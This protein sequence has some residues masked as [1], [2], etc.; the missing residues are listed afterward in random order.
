LAI[1]AA[2]AALAACGGGT[3][4]GGAGSDGGGTSDGGG[5]GN[6][7]GEA[8]AR[9]EADLVI[10]ADQPKADSL[11]AAA[12]EWGEANGLTVAVQAV[13]GD[14]QGS[15]I[16][17]NQAGN[18]PD[19]VIGAHD[20]IGNLVQ[21]GAIIPVQL[22][23]DASEKV[24]QIGLTAVTYDGQTYGVPY[25]VETIALYANTALTDN[26]TPSS[27]GELVAAGEAGGAEN[28]LSVQVGQTGDAYHMQPLYTSGGGYLFGTDAAGNL[29]PTDVGVGKKGSIAAAKKIGEL[30]QQE[31]LKTSIA[32]ENYI[33]LFTDGKAA[34]LISGPWAVAQIETADIDYELSPVP[35]FEG[36][37]PPRPFAGV[38]SFFVASTGQNQAFAQQFVDELATSPDIPE[39][40]FAENKLPPVNLELQEKL[41]ADNPE[42]VDI[43][44]YAEEAEPMPSIPEMSAIWGPLGQAEAAIVGGADPETTMV[45]AGEEIISKIG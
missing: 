6:A 29:D 2:S 35:G 42:L 16:T 32:G 24:A 19:I 1:G 5:A 38:N 33:D 10:W 43:A 4:N 14:L 13:A 25:A 7:V 26:P 37:D 12:Q 28:V 44:R 11:D 20:W 45:S 30:G 22:P 40:M 17:A 9:A 18:G 21:N 41:S 36:M 3:S 34:Y 23:A 15:F 27:M 39:A 8:P 31:V